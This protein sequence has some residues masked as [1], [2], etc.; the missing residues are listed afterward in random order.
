MLSAQAGVVVL[1][2]QR[3]RPALASSPFPRAPAL[4]TLPASS[5]RR[6]GETSVRLFLDPPPGGC[7]EA[8]RLFSAPGEQALGQGRGSSGVGRGRGSPAPVPSQGEPASLLL[9]LSPAPPIPWL[10]AKD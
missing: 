5:F 6:W 7:G 10:V 2:P 3:P 1:A 4:L 8:R 9:G